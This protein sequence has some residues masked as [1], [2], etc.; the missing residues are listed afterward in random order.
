MTFDASDSRG[1]GKVL[2]WEPLTGQKFRLGD[3][4]IK[5]FYR[6]IGCVFNDKHFYA[7]I[8]ADDQVQNTIFDLEDDSLWKA[9]DSVLLKSLPK[10]PNANLMPTDL[11][12]I[13]EE[14]ALEKA[15]KAKIAG[16]RFSECGLK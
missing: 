7:N 16:V 10:V 4:R 14:K 15:L 8:Q 12:I 2:F 13:E 3:P 6:S 11:D 5:S 1:R 9:M